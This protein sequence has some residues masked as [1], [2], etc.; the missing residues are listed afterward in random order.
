[1]GKAKTPLWLYTA[2]VIITG[3]VVAW[4]IAIALAAL[5]TFGNWL[6]FS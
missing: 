1:M 6:F 5:L 3:I 2:G 4:T